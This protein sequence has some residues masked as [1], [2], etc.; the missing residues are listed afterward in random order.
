MVGLCMHGHI[1]YVSFSS[2]FLEGSHIHISTSCR[3]GTIHCVLRAVLIFIAGSV[4]RF[5]LILSLLLI[6]E[7]E[8]FCVTGEVSYYG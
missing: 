6:P 3:S 8:V 4:L 1:L 2:L 7:F 5:Q